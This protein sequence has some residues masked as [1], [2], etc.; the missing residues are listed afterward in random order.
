M[1]DKEGH[2]KAYAEY[3]KQLRQNSLA[4]VKPKNRVPILK[5]SQLT[6]GRLTAWQAF[7]RYGKL[8]STDK[9]L[10]IA[11][12][13]GVGHLLYDCKLEQNRHW[14]QNEWSQAVSTELINEGKKKENGSPPDP[15][16]LNKAG[17]EDIKERK[18]L[19][20]HQ[21]EG[22]RLQ[23]LAASGSSVVVIRYLEEHAKGKNERGDM[24][25]SRAFLKMK[26][27]DMF[28]NPISKFTCEMK[29]CL[30]KKL[31]E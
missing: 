31:R 21:L 26:S 22:N 29:S 6:F 9:V 14:K 30:G 15:K 10:F 4:G 16:A 19:C 24:K 11:A 8:R 5:R 13:G 12:A 2:G 25:E 18:F 28:F 27:F 7:D 1:Q 23:V 17:W 3:V 20:L